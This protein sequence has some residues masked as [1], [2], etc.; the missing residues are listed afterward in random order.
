MQIKKQRKCLLLE[1][2]STEWELEIV[3]LREPRWYFL[4]I[5][6]KAVVVLFLVSFFLFFPCQTLEPVFSQML[7]PW[8]VNIYRNQGII[9]MC[10][11]AL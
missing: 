11:N 5:K 3:A 6:L 4:I 7:F 8:F 2:K 1:P 9:N 10:Q